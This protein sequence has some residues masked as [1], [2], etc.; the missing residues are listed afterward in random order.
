MSD[1]I[2]SC[3]ICGAPSTTNHDDPAAIPVNGSPGAGHPNPLPPV[4]LCAEHWAAYRIDWLL[5]G[6]CDDHYG[7]ALTHCPQ[8]HREIE[9]L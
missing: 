8:H 5:L 3:V 1:D 4:E 2:R 7:E 6:W 9:A